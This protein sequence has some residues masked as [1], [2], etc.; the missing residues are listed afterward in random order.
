MTYLLSCL[1]VIGNANTAGYCAKGL[2]WLICQLHNKSESLQGFEYAWLPGQNKQRCSTQN[3]CMNIWSLP[4]KSPSNTMKLL[5]STLNQA[6]MQ[7]TLRQLILEWYPQNSWSVPLVGCFWSLKSKQCLTTGPALIWE[8]T[9]VT[10]YQVI[11]RKLLS[12]TEAQNTMIRSRW[13]P[14][15]ARSF[16]VACL[17]IKKYTI[18]HICMSSKSRYSSMMLTIVHQI[19]GPSFN[20]VAPKKPPNH[21]RFLSAK[22]PQKRPEHHERTA[23][24]SPWRETCKCVEWNEQ[25]HRNSQKH[26]ESF[27]ALPTARLHT[28]IAWL[29]WTEK[30]TKLKMKRNMQLVT[31]LTTL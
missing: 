19:D 24:W 16:I 29:P 5:P 12:L 8:K 21:R 9:P 31:L 25:S 15:T 30:N 14:N 27:I 28:C 18:I 22:V 11:S 2:L 3:T 17:N 26:A 6:E 4:L 23:R 20:W 7:W 10:L 13:S 1:S